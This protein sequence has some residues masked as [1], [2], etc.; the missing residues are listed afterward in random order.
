MEEIE[1]KVNGYGN[2][3][4]VLRW[5][6]PITGERKTKSSGTKKRREAERKA[7]LLEKELRAGAYKPLSKITWDDFRVNYERKLSKQAE[8]TRKTATTALNHLERV[9]RPKMLSAITSQTMNHF[10]ETLYEE[11][12]RPTSIDGVLSH[13]KSA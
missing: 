13:V 5:T 3:N 9:L 1:V 8:N 6:D 7:A 12:R 2:R 10:V 4:L 11:G